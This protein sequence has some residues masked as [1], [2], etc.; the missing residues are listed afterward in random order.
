MLLK[1]DP[2][3]VYDFLVECRGNP[4]ALDSTLQALGA[5]VLLMEGNEYIREG[6]HYVMRVLRNADYI[7]WA[8]EHQGYTRIVKFLGYVPND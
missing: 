8:V 6:G 7:A 5:A 2:H 3:T 4:A 1:Y